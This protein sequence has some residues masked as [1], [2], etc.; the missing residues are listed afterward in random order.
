[1]RHFSS[2]TLVKSTKNQTFITGI[3]RFILET[4]TIVMTNGMEPVK[5]VGKSK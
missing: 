4:F 2:E 5:C 3:N 1:M